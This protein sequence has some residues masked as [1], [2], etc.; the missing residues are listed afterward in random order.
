MIGGKQEICMDLT[1][2]RLTLSHKVY[3]LIYI[4]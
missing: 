3:S 2:V 4:V 1:H